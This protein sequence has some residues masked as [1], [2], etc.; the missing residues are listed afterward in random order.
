MRS[1]RAQQARAGDSKRPRKSSLRESGPGCPPAALSEVRSVSAGL[2]FRPGTS[3]WRSWGVPAPVSPCSVGGNS[4]FRR[5]DVLALLI[6]LS[7]TCSL[8][9]A[10]VCV[11]GEIVPGVKLHT[12]F[13]SCGSR[14]VRK[15]LRV[16]HR[17]TRSV[18]G[19]LIEGGLLHRCRA[20]ALGEVAEQCVP[21]RHLH[22]QF[23]RPASDTPA[24]HELEPAAHWA[25]SLRS[26]DL[27]SS[28][29]QAPAHVGLLPLQWGARRQLASQAWW[30][31]KCAS[32]KA[33][34]HTPVDACAV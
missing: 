30:P 7:F 21:Q 25:R 11:L 14:G 15:S 27:S 34:R 12:G 3:P 20:R 28:G 22:C 17:Q 6:T 2:R 5:V 16:A 1:L 19:A 4:F 33:G 23:R 8:Q 9:A 13:A 24:R 10:A 31:S 32:C 29:R 18:S 26:A